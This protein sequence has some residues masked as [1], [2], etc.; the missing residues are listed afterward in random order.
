MECGSAA[1]AIWDAWLQHAVPAPRRH[2]LLLCKPRPP[3]QRQRQQFCQPPAPATSAEGMV[4]QLIAL[5]LA[6]SPGVPQAAGG[7]KQ[8]SI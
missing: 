7:E 8:E 2:L 5:L 6:Q 1:P 3:Q 4:A